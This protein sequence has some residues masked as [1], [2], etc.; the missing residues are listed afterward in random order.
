MF[1]HVT[2][3]LS[4][5]YAL[6]VTHLL[7][8]AT[9]LIIARERVKFSGLQAAW[10]AAA[11]L[12]VFINWLQL[13]PLRAISHWTLTDVTLL[14]LTA[15]VQYFTCSLVSVRV[16]REGLVNMDAAFQR[17]R[18]TFLSAFGGLLLLA[19][20]LNY[21]ERNQSAG[22]AS[23]D[24]FGEDLLIV[25]LAVPLVISGF[26]RAVWLQWFSVLAFLG[27]LLAGLVLFTPLG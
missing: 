25:P 20:I 19:A 27:L 15:V 13:W 6:A 4:F 14:M 11:L 8:S 21:A 23:T 24:W 7:A 2:L 10:M 5:I 12:G 1:E 18:P 9:E 3:L 16:E 26:V 17:Q 22:L